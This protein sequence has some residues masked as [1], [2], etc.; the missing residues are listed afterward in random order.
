MEM[1]A[2][3]NGQ[4]SPAATWRKDENCQSSHSFDIRSACDDWSDNKWNWHSHS[5][6]HST[7]SFDASVHVCVFMRANCI[8]SYLPHSGAVF[9][10][11][12]FPLILKPPYSPDLTTCDVCFI[13]RFKTGLKGP[14][15]VPVQ[16]LWNNVTQV[17]QLYQKR[18]SRYASSNDRP[19]TQVQS[20]STARV[21][22]YYTLCLSSSNFDSPT[23]F[24]NWGLCSFWT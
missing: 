17:S 18:S 10:K 8:S 5:S 12:Q 11:N 2:L 24:Q 14:C 7:I 4:D 21:T 20:D 22:K 1:E 3:K 16:D 9:S 23:N 15:F 19:S 13:L 6:E